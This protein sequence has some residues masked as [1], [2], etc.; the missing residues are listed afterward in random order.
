MSPWAHSHSRCRKATRPQSFI[1]LIKFRTTIWGGAAAPCLVARTSGGQKRITYSDRCESSDLRCCLSWKCVLLFDQRF[2][3]DSLGLIDVPSPAGRCCPESPAHHS[4]LLDA[5]GIR[6]DFKI[7]QYVII[8]DW[9][10]YDRFDTRLWRCGAIGIVIFQ[11]HQ[12]LERISCCPPPN[13]EHRRSKVRNFQRASHVHCLRAR[14]IP[15]CLG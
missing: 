7:D 15:L 2:V 12:S 13:V 5:P 1:N 11:Q 6:G 14:P 3:V 4:L 9:W 8:R 10:H